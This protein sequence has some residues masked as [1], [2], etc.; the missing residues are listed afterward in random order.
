MANIP[1]APRLL[2]LVPLLQCAGFLPND[3]EYA[4]LLKEARVD[5]PVLFISGHAD[6]LIPLHRTKVGPS[7][8]CGVS[9]E[10][11]M[12]VGATAFRLRLMPCILCTFNFCLFLLLYRSH[13]FA[14]SWM[15]AGFECLRRLHLLLLALQ[16]LLLPLCAAGDVQELMDTF[17]PAAVTLLEHPGE[18]CLK[19]MLA[20][21]ELVFICC[22]AQCTL[23]L[24]AALVRPACA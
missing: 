8:V 2:L 1:P 18:R 22:A 16:L 21:V 5:V 9:P 6:A 11:Q 20:G 15:T 23:S 24:S 13:C 3:P 14:T 10:Q 12:T 7:C 17:D 4:A 19:I